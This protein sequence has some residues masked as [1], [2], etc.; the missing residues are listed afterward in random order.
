MGTEALGGL[1][2]CDVLC[3]CCLPRATVCCWCCSCLILLSFCLLVDIVLRSLGCPGDGA[4]SPR[5]A[6]AP[7][8]GPRR[9]GLWHAGDSLTIRWGSSLMFVD[10]EAPVRSCS[11]PKACAC[12]CS[13]LCVVCCVCWGVPRLQRKCARGENQFACLNLGGVL[14]R[15]WRVNLCG[16][17]L[18]LR[19]DGHAGAAGGHFQV[20]QGA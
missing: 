9:R 20:R 7:G 11:R 1:V 10:A 5:R 14:V 13:V 3:L 17:P 8:A 12:A 2:C 16:L 15:V 19:A 6:D 18:P 4:V